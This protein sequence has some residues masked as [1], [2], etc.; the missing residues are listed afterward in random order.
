MAAAKA[1]E[2]PF[3]TDREPDRRTWTFPYASYANDAMPHPKDMRR[4]LETGVN[5]GD[6]LPACFAAAL[7]S[8]QQ[9]KI[10]STDFFAPA[11]KMRNDLVEWI[12]R[13]WERPLVFNPD[14]KYH[15]M[16]QACHDLGI[17][18]AE[19]NRF[20]P[21]PS[22]AEGRLKIYSER[23]DTFHFCDAEMM[24]FSEMMH[25]RGLPILFRTWRVYDAQNPKVGTFLGAT[26]T[27]EALSRNGVS[28]AI[29]VDLQHT[30]TTDSRTAHYKIV[31]SGSLEDL[32]VVHRAPKRPRAS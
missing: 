28:E 29:V 24:A 21:W 19:R 17:P 4:K 16:M 5:N 7:E 13:H 22:D 18:E 25:E 30:G 26:P 23:V 11:A 31:D 8:L 10:V 6:C 9:G 3:Y 2:R 14:L 20:G 1:R 27:S 12:K 15:E 32:I